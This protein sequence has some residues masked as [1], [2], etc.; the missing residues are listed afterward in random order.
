MIFNI[1]AK[2]TSKKIILSSAGLKNVILRKNSDDEFEFIFGNHKMKMNN[3]FA[4][5]ISPAVSKIHASDPIINSINFTD[6]INGIPI[7]EDVLSILQSLSRGFSVEVR[8]DQ[9][10][11]IQSLSILLDNQELFLLIND[12]FDT[13]ISETNIDQYLT[14]LKFFSKFLQHAA[15]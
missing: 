14:Y 3:I 9:A 12:K 7:T 8:D 5:F 2:M 15:L 13:N 10:I 6:R 4:D 1:K 11:Q